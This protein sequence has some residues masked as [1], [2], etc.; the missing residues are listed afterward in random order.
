LRILNRDLSKVVIIDNSPQA[1]GYQISNG[2]PIESWYDDKS[3]RELAK[4]MD[5]LE[6][7]HGVDDVRPMIDEH[8]KLHERIHKTVTLANHHQISS[9]GGLGNLGATL[10]P[11]SGSFLS[12]A[13]S[14]DPT[15]TLNISGMATSNPD[16]SNH[17]EV[18]ATMLYDMEKPPSPSDEDN[19]REEEDEEKGQR[20]L[21][22]RK[23]ETVAGGGGI[24]P[25]S[26]MTTR[27]NSQA[28]DAAT[29]LAKISL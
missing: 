20:E 24:A 18:D 15:S 29:N 13:G 23:K 19:E 7:L 12:N 11:P 16:T 26:T 5:F 28:L 10:T 2:V 21:R 9:M 14:S 17:G 25:A 6:T 8:Y 22:S 1:F 4:L 3:D 27:S